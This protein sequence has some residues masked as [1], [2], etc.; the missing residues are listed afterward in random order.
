MVAIDPARFGPDKTVV[1]VRRGDVLSELVAWGRCDL[2]E[3]VARIRAVL[4]RVGATTGRRGGTSAT[5]GE[6]WR[7]SRQPVA[8]GRVVVDKVGVGAGVVDRLAELG[9]RVEPFNGGRS[10]RDGDRFLN[11]RAEAYWHLRDL[12]ERGEI[13]VPADEALADELLAQVWRPT[14]DGKVMLESKET[15]RGRIGRSPDRADAVVMA[16]AEPTRR[17]VAAT[18]GS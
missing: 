1:A 3:S 9:Y 5:W 2:T 17:L 11:R 16:F 8:V 10:P 7:R 13:A 12:L 14:A 6:P 4:E 15:L 18:W